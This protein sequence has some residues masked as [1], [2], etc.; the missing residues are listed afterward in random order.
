MVSSKALD[1]MV[2]WSNNVRSLN[3]GKLGDGLVALES[4]N[5]DKS[6]VFCD[7]S[8]A[9]YGGFI[10]GNDDSEVVGSWTE[11]ESG[12]SSTWREL[13][14]VHR[15]LH[16]SINSLEGQKVIVNTDNKNVAS[17]LNVGS[18]KPY[19][20]DIAITVDDVCRKHSIE[21]S[22]KWVLRADNYETDLLSRCTDSDDWSVTNDVYTLLEE[23]WGPHT[24]DCFACN[25]NTKCSVFYSKY[26]C[27]GTSGIDAFKFK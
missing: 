21:V 2:Y 25:Y 26:W 12:L 10:E 22:P 9:G 8:G 3:S 11:S 4:I 13:K 14:A 18:R 7:A 16:S 17:I 23:K 24:F 15:V 6:I 1:E 19:L 27:P 20:Q 5:I